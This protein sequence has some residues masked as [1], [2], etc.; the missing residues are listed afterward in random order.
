M[1]KHTIIGII[2]LMS[3]SLLG[4]VGLQLYWINDAIKVKQEQFDRSVNEALASVVQKLETRE[5]VSL[6]KDQIGAVSTDTMIRAEGKA[7]PPVLAVKKKH[8]PTPRPAKGATAEQ[9]QHLPVSKQQTEEQ[10][11]ALHKAD[12]LHLYKREAGKTDRPI[13]VMARPVLRARATTFR[14]DSA[15]NAFVY[16]YGNTHIV[17][18]RPDSALSFSTTA[19]PPTNYLFQVSADTIRLSAKSIDSLKAMANGFAAISPEDI[20]SILVRR[21]SIFIVKQPRVVEFRQVH[22]PAAAMAISGEATGKSAVTVIAAKPVAP[23]VK[24]QKKDVRLP[25]SVDLQK[26]AHRKNKLNEVVE[27]MVVE[28]VA[29]DAPLQERLNLGALKRLL[30]TELLSKGIN[31]DFGYYVITGNRDTLAAYD[32]VHA[33]MVPFSRYKTSLFPNDIFEKPDYLSVYFPNR[34]AYVLQS[35]WGMLSLSALFTLVIVTTFGTTI[36]VIYKQKKLSEMKN[37]FINNM[38]HEFKTPIATISLATDAVANPKVYQQPDKIKY[39]ADIIRQENKRMNKQVENVLQI[40]LLEKNQF[41]MHLQQVDV[42]LLIQRAFESFRLQVEE[43]AGQIRLQLNAMQHELQSDEVH[44]YNVICNLLDNANKYS[45]ASPEINLTTQNLA[46][47]LV[48]AVEDKG[49][50]M[51]KETQKRVFDKFYRVPTGNLHNVKGFGLG[52]SYVKA[53]VQAHH[54]QVRLKSDPGKGSRF[55]VF[56]P[57]R[58]MS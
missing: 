32:A 19:K 4:V 13:S 55:E 42:H 24:D 7:L 35:L 15:K 47:G 17:R 48:I 21:D 16:W 40:A 26:I 34:D 30:Q 51:T 38:T 54:G 29:K 44:L 23:R 1:S 8:A 12:S 46:G 3:I 58:N 57:L 9:P 33:G 25:A 56:L 5:A 11:M 53:I 41:R 36:H 39:Y 14:T 37:D 22:K 31:V 43:R 18:A 28:Y 20:A 2:I 49:V 27:K 10:A 50:G 52:L 6:V 45:P